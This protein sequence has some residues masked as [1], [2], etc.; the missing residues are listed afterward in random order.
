M[1]GG[2][3]SAEFHVPEPVDALRPFRGPFAPDGGQ[4]NIHL[5]RILNG[6]VE[7]FEQLGTILEKGPHLFDGLGVVLRS[8]FAPP[9]FDINGFFD[10]VTMKFKN[11][12]I[13]E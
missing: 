1:A 5:L 13:P 12:E 7:F 10:H 11:V 4:V 8:A 2:S 6:P 3:R 9:R